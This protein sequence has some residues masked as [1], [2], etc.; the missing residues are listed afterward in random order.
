MAQ[1]AETTFKNRIRPLLKALP[2]SWWEKIQQVVIRGTPDILGVINGR[3]V[4]LELKKD[5]KAKIDELQIHKLNKIRQAGG[6]TFVVSPEN[7]DGVYS[8]LKGLSGLIE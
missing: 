6:A 7:W 3:F 4:A 2:N 8:E 5:T 1:K